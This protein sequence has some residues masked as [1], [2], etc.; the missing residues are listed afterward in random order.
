MH[1]SVGNDFSDGN[2]SPM[3]IYGSLMVLCIAVD[4]SLP[5]SLGKLNSTDYL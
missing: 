4:R 5:A 3:N 1:G 2:V